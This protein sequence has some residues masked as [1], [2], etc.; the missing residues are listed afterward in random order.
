MSGLQRP[1]AQAPGLHQLL[2]PDL[3]QHRAI[4]LLKQGHDV[5]VQAPT[6]AGKT[7]IFEFWLRSKSRRGQA[8]YTVPT[9][10]LANDKYSEWLAKDWDVGIATGDLSENLKA[11][12]VVG[13]LEAQRNR[14]LEEPFPQLLVIDEYQMI[15]DSDRGL[16]YELAIAQAPPET[17]LLLLSGSVGNPEAVVGWLRHLG[18][19]AEGVYHDERPVPLEEVSL[20]GFRHK[21][22]RQIRDYW[23]RM[24]AQAL[25]E[26]LGPVLIFS[27]RRAAAENLAAELAAQLPNPQPL[28]LTPA[29]RQLVDERMAKMLHS[30]IAFHHSGL[31]YAAR[32]GVIEPLAKAGQLRLVVAT[33]G[34]AAGINFSLRSVA[35]AADSYRV[36]FRDHRLEPNEILQMFGRAG[37]RG[38]D[39]TGYILVGA[40]QIRMRDA[41]PLALQRSRLIDWN[42]LLNIMNQACARNESPYRAAVAVQDRLFATHPIPLGVETSLEHP[43]APCG[44]ATDPERARLVRRKLTEY[45][46]SQGEWEA[47]LTKEEL[48]LAEILVPI[49]PDPESE[50]P[51]EL[52][53]VLSHL[54]ALQQIVTDRLV[55]VGKERN[56]I[57]YGRSIHLADR[58]LN[59]RYLLTKTLRRLIAWNGRQVTGKRWE[60]KIAP[61]LEACLAARQTPVLRYEHDGRKCR[62]VV[63]L[64]RFKTLTPVDRHG[65]ALFRPTKR[66]VGPA[67]CRTCRYAS[68]CRS[69]APASATATYW[70]ELQLTHP[71]GCPTDRGRI[72]SFLGREDGLA[73]TAALGD[74]NY[75]LEELIFDLANLDAGFRFCPE[76]AR[77]AGA[78]ARACKQTY[79]SFNAPGYLENGLPPN[80]GFG[81]SDL[82]ADLYRNPAAARK[83]TG[84]YLEVGDIERILIEWRSRLRRIVQAP[85]LDSDRWTDLQR[86]ARHTLNET[87][88]PARTELPSLSPLQRERPDH[89]LSWRTVRHE[90]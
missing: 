39:S 8:I 62:A 47:N 34:L 59:R 49:Y 13:T 31:G 14:L 33:M 9:R 45:R 63:D 53:P 80:Y 70:R 73:L 61:Q 35:V 1:F 12:V 69:L 41:F 79:G 50:G 40:N 65:V 6:G 86:L 44:L 27:P 87:K 2:A 56:R 4:S 22:P 66:K 11:P 75:P 28:E 71:N 23:P 21:L 52:I 48:P 67:L 37:R 64:A 54:P 89:R 60:E 68:V 90:G 42:T 46:N 16:H 38:I 83:R 85:A 30:R 55:P 18:R 26:N 19:R 77:W 10:A 25:A 51:V 88:S 29:Q 74:A 58:L 24:M 78:L 57:V 43:Q 7:L 15:G 32:A 17:Q 5:V 72:V 36:D 76:E 81:A 82:I 3:W 20:A 84:D